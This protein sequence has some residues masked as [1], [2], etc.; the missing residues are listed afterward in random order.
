MATFT[1]VPLSMLPLGS[2][3]RCHSGTEV[4]DSG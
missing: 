2:S 1:M 4:V 3:R